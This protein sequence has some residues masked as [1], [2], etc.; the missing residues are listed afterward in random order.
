MTLNKKAIFPLTI[1]IFSIVYFIEAI[2]L[3][4][5]VTAEGIRPSFVPLVLGALSCLFSLILTIKAAVSKSDTKAE[6]AADEANS[7]EHGQSVWP[8]V[9]T[10]IAISIYIALL[11][12]LGYV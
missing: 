2:K 5:P 1:L 7:A 12:T 11:T 10:I 4:A 6:V 9:V 3:G 8:A